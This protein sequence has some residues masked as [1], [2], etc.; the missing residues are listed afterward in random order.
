MTELSLNSWVLLIFPDQKMVGEFIGKA[1]GGGGGGGG[2]LAGTGA[3]S[4][5]RVTLA[6][7]CT[8]FLCYLG[9]ETYR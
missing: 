8:I 9:C 5:P 7:R 4:L 3:L 1:G 2:G 6:H